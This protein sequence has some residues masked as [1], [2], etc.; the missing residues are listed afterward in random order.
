MENTAGAVMLLILCVVSAGR[1]ADMMRQ[2]IV[3]NPGTPDVFYCPLHKPKSFHNMLVKARPLSK[4]CE[5]KGRPLPEG[6][7]SDCYND[8]DET[9]FACAEKH[10]ILPRLQSEEDQLNGIW[11]AV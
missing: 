11:E 1:A 8:V 5:F 4:L 10:R 9:E 2:S 7:K 3:F 6:Y